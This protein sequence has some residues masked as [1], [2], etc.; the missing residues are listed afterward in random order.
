MRWIASPIGMVNLEQLVQLGIERDAS[1]NP[2]RFQII[3]WSATGDRFAV[4]DVQRQFGTYETMR[5]V[6]E[7]WALSAEVYVLDPE[8]PA[9][10]STGDADRRSTG[11]TEGG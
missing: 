4:A 11:S 1:G 6:F 7:R 9:P 10:T 8:A 3:G 2:D 5:D